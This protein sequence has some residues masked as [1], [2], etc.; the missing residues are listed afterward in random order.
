MVPGA[1][2]TRHFGEVADEILRFVPMQLELSERS[3]AHGRDERILVE[4]L[5]RSVRI[6]TDMVRR[7]ASGESAE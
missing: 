2:D 6:A 4:P 7:A 1:T 3:G 5:A